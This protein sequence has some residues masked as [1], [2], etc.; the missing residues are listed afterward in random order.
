M[1]ST[2]CANLFSTL[3]NIEL[4]NANVVKNPPKI[5]QCCFARLDTDFSWFS[6]NSKF[7]MKNADEH[8]KLLD[9]SGEKCKIPRTFLPECFW[10][11]T[12]STNEK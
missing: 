2:F 6:V 9:Y 4:L 5:L 7:P 8:F 1:F 3:I 11:Q 10:E 12:S